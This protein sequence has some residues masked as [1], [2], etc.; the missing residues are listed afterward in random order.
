MEEVSSIIGF[1]F[2]LIGLCFLLQKEEMG[3]YLKKKNHWAMGDMFSDETYTTSCR[4][5]GIGFLILG[6]VILAFR[7]FSYFT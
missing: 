6:L 4:N 3:E 2:A 1:F 5:A 7:L